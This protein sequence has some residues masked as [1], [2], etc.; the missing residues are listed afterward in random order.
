[1]VVELAEPAVGEPEEFRK[2]CGADH[3][4]LFGF[5]QSDGKLRAEGGAGALRTGTG[6][7]SNHR[8]ADAVL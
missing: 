2:D 1:M 7:V 5:N 6:T 8:A 3:R 4:S